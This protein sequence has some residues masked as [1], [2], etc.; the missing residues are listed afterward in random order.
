MG[1]W[2]IAC[3]LLLGGNRYPFSESAVSWLVTNQVLQLSDPSPAS[4]KF[5]IGETAKIHDEINPRF[6]NQVGSRFN[7]VA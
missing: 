2:A 4:K 6:G 5:Q 3:S 1:V 7:S